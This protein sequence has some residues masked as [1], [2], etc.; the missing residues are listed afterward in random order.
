MEIIS[1]L[2]LID[3]GL[4][5][6]FADVNPI[7]GEMEHIQDGGKTSFFVGSLAFGSPH[8]HRL[9]RLSRRD[10]FFSLLYMLSYLLNA[11]MLFVD[12]RYTID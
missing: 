8:A 2:K 5:Q 7:T 12:P 1:Q 11:Q 9:A 10:D 3:F 6:K 4:A